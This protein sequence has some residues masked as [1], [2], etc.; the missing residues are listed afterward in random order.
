MKIL[1]LKL[2]QKRLFLISKLTKKVKAMGIRF[3]NPEFLLI[4][5]IAPGLPAC[6]KKDWECNCTVNGGDYSTV[7]QNATKSKDG[8]RIG[9]RQGNDVYKC[10]VH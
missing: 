5:A 6:A 8:K 7:V 2:K 9:S 3:S 1:L 10:K 4:V